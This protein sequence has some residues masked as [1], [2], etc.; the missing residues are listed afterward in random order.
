MKKPKVYKRKPSGNKQ[1]SLP[2]V[3]ASKKGYDRNWQKYRFRF[4]HHNPYCYVCPNKATVVD[5][6][7][8]HK[9]DKALFELLTNHIPLCK[10]H[11]DTITGKFDR[12]KTAK[13]EDKLSYLNELR[14]QNGISRKVKVL[15]QYIKA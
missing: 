11:H 13:T 8:P 7:V 5:H 4:L 12:H 2:G 10:M 14:K 3:S 6:V 1:F 15:P 9:G